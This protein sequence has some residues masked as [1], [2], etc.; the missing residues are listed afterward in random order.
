VVHLGLG[1]EAQDHLAPFRVGHHALHHALKDEELLHLLV[2]LAHQRVAL[3]VVGHEQQRL[4]LAPLRGAHAL[5][6]LVLAQLQANAVA[7][8]MRG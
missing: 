8:R 5:Q 6:Q 7:L 4:E 1:G 2:P 3:A